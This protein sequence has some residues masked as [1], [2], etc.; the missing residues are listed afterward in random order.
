MG[1]TGL[2]AIMSNGQRLDLY[3]GVDV[4]ERIDYLSAELSFMKEIQED[5]R[6]PNFLSKY[7]DRY[8][9]DTE[10][11]IGGFTILRDA[12]NLANTDIEDRR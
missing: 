4:N 10:P 2:T 11:V 8:V 9:E 1:K 12:L 7:I 6:C 3:E 5:D